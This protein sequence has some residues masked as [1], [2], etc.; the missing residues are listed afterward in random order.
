MTKVIV[1]GGGIAGAACASE[2]GDHDVEVTV[3]DRND[4]LQFQ[5]LLYQVASSQVPAE[6]IARPHSAVFRDTPSVTVLTSTV[7]GIDFGTRTVTTA[8]GTVGPADYLVLA[9]GAKPNF[10]GVT[11]ASEHSFPL[12]SVV[13]AE[14]LRLH[15]RDQ[16]RLHCAPS[17]PPEPLNVVIVGGGPTGVETAGAIAELFNALRE[18]ERLHENVSVHLVDHGKAVL[19]PFSEK[20]H[21]YALE[22]LTEHGVTVTFGVAVT[23][24]EPELV[25]LSDGTTLQTNT[26]I[27][28]GGES[29]SDV[30]AATGATPGR[31][32]R[33][34]VAADLSVPGF[35]GVFAVGDVA[36]IPGPDDRALPQLG[37]V[38]LQSGKWAGRN[39]L[40]IIDGKSPKP[41]HYH[42]KGIMAMIGRNAA[43][44]EIGAHRHQV[45]GP[46]AFAAWL[47]LHAILLSGTHS[48]VDAF[49]NW[50]DD[51][52]HHGRAPDLELEGTPT[53]IAWAD[54]V[55][56]KPVISANAES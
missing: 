42:D 53:R 31:G 37:S 51:Y 34:D 44:A 13:D 1:V 56:D 23:E 49:L 55:S 17:P 41:F 25:H 27:W 8:D 16:L 5:P 45:D 36:N 7:T 35:P 50:A 4:Y 33:I 11:G 21:A 18:E 47:G 9:A 2:L 48:R 54:D 28:G 29:A 26:V 52:F 19:A 15:L 32:G 6:D 38:A 40:A 39:I 12:Y 24:V 43:V 20:S 3:I 14:R 10:F 30:A 22:K 46:I